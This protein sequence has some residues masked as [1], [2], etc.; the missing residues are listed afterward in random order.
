MISSLL[1][2]FLSFFRLLNTLKAKCISMPFKAFHIMRDTSVDL[3]KPKMDEISH[4]SL[5]QLQIELKWN[6]NILN[7]PFW[8]VVV[9]NHIQNEFLQ[10]ILKNKDTVEM[11][12]LSPDTLRSLEGMDWTRKR[13]QGK[14]ASFHRQM[15]KNGVKK[16]HKNPGFFQIW[17]RKFQIIV[18]LLDLNPV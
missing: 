9:Q 14:V 3:C 10:S 13:L 7:R 18:S 17:S 8:P 2:F 5:E 12:N 16:R 4:A 1:V 15:E 11:P 6:P